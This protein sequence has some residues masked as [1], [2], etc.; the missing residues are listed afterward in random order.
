M[1]DFRLGDDFAAVADGMETVTLLRRGSGPAVGTVIARAL[2]RAM[3]AGEATVVNRGDVHKRVPGGGRHTAADVTWHLPAAELPDAPKLGDVI[4]DAAGRRWT[5]LEVKLATLGSRWRCPARNVA[6]AYG[7]D[8]TVSLLRATSDPANP[9]ETTWRLWRTGV[10]ARIQPIDARVST[11]ED[12]PSTRLR[13]RV[14]V[15]DD[16]DVDHTCRLRGPDGTVY[17][18]TGAVGAERIGELQVIEA[19]V[20]RA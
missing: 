13:F 18:I 3:T 6:V 7:L 20:V 10:R 4:L 17:T 5:I 19:E 9:G 12:S 2:R 16:L 15:E 8:D 14:F 1:A 11:T